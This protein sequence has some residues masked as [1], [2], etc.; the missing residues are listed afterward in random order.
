MIGIALWIH[1]RKCI[2]IFYDIPSLVVGEIQRENG[3]GI[4]ITS[5]SLI[6]NLST[7]LCN[8]PQQ[9]NTAIL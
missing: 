8:F 1:L 2:V 9:Y 3:N 6:L 5:A 4:A 7:F